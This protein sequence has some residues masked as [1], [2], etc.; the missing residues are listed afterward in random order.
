MGWPMREWTRMNRHPWLVHGRVIDFVQH[1]R[2]DSHTLWS[3]LTT[4]AGMQKWMKESQTT[5][6]LIAGA[7]FV[8]TFEGRGRVGARRSASRALGQTLRS[9]ERRRLG[10]DPWLRI[11]SQ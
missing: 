3:A 2:V 7:D 5:L 4:E 11:D 8:L 10:I 9:G 1:I 6:P